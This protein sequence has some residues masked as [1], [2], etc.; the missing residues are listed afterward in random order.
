MLAATDAAAALRL[1]EG[2]ARPDVLFTDVV[3][4]GPLSSRALAERAQRMLPGLAVLFTSGYTQNSIVHNGELDHGINL[5]SKP[6]RTEDLARQMRAVLDQARKPRQAEALRV[7]LVED[8]V[9]VRMTTAVM[10]ADLGH[11]VLEAETGAEAVDRLIQGV[12]LV[13]CDLG[14]PDMDGWTLVDQ[15]RERLPGMPVIVA[16]GGCQRRG[17]R[18]GVA[19]Q[20]L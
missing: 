9:L 5:L 16:S 17:P 10:L 1:L 6:W 20:A 4:P 7:L 3:M 15:V 11:D 12:D 14:L 19:W 13:V 18:R 8:E 2:G